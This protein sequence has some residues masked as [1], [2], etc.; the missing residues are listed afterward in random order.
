MVHRW[1]LVMKIYSSETHGFMIFEVKEVI[2]LNSNISDL[3]QMAENAA[4]AGYKHIAVTFP[5]QSELSSLSIASLVKCGFTLQ[6]MQGQ[7]AIIA[8]SK[9][10]YEL[11]RDLELSTVIATV[12]NREELST[13]KNGTVNGG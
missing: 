2:H 10:V 1:G 8:P 7:F 4:K 11:I 3:E 13:I 12:R 6:D 5:P 9:Q